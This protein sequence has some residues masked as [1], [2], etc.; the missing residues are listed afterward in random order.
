MWKDSFAIGVNHIDAQHKALVGCIENLGDKAQK[1][2][3]T[4]FLEAL[5]FLKEYAVQH[6]SDEEEYQELIGFDERKEHKTMHDKFI[7]EVLLFEKQMNDFGN[8][9]AIRTKFNSF[10]FN[11]LIKHV[12]FE[13]QK[14]KEYY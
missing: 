12:C 3:P 7:Q 5:D 10:L 2:D 8:S 6:F 9:V 14:M 13:D 1:E 11:W 4:D